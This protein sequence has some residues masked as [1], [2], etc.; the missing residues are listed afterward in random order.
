MLLT[1]RLI[2]RVVRAD[3]TQNGFLNMNLCLLQGYGYANSGEQLVLLLNKNG[4]Y[5]KWPLLPRVN[6]TWHLETGK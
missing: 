3:S 1:R 4:L 2:G 6:V 5:G